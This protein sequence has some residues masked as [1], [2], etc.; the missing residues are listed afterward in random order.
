VGTSNID[1]LPLLEDD[2]LQG[3]LS[4]LRVSD[5]QELQA[6]STTTLLA[7]V[8]TRRK[9][10]IRMM[11][12]IADLLGRLNAWIPGNT[13]L[14][15]LPN[16]GESLR[17]G[18]QLRRH[19]A[20]CADERLFARDATDLQA[21]LGQCRAAVE[22]LIRDCLPQRVSVAPA[23]FLW[24]PDIPYSVARRFG[25]RSHE[26]F[27]SD[28]FNFFEN[29]Q[30]EL[31]ALNALIERATPELDG[32]LAAATFR[33]DLRQLEDAVLEKIESMLRNIDDQGLLSPQI[34][35]R[36]QQRTLE[37]LRRLRESLA[38]VTQRGEARDELVD[39]LSLGIWKQRW[40]VFEVW[41]LCRTIGVVLDRGGVVRPSDRIKNGEWI[42]KYA[43]DSA[44]CL[45]IELMGTPL[46]VYYQLR[47]PGQGRAH[48]P[49]IALEI[50]GAG[51][52]VVADPKHGKT[53]RRTSMERVCRR[54]Q[55]TFDPVLS[56][57]MNYF[58][59]DLPWHEV[60]GDTSMIV[61]TGMTPDSDTM[62]RV[63]SAM[64]EAL[65]CAWAQQKLKPLPRH[66]MILFDVSLSTL[67]IRD[68]MI[69]DL[70]ARAASITW[71][72]SSRVLPFAD[73]VLD[74]VPLA[75]L[76]REALSFRKVNGGTRI[77]PAFD[78]AVRTL[79]GLRGRRELWI[80]SDGESE[81]QEEALNE[82]LEARIK[83]TVYHCS[84]TTSKMVVSHHRNMCQQ[85][86]G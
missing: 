42:L 3:L 70:C 12:E 22:N 5:K 31:A 62:L 32:P 17:F 68:G 27:H 85:I 43:N 67:K 63:D 79:R 66:L 53:Y 33:G 14:I 38:G 1:L 29:V 51:F 56:C 69:D 40:R 23:V 7:A 19:L 54:Y 59:R 6:F 80:Y 18:S 10:F 36:D 45:E 4:D 78:S 86:Y 73:D 37:Q 72:E 20:L 57:V 16:S 64:D 77:A 52:I 28:D 49:D 24:R 34:D 44:P 8:L 65:E 55:R 75:A 11:T 50:P 60:D 13:E 46:H 61:A 9:P 25:S 71:T 41:S 81:L 47:R 26:L 21:L 48:M 58:E 76:N 74:P 2:E 84:K 82:A 30:E 35:A 83:I 39:F 15:T